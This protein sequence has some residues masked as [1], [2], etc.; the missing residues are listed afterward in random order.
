VLITS[1]QPANSSR[2]SSS[3]RRVSTS[4]SFDGSS[5]SSTLPPVHQRLRQV[6]APAL[7]AGEV[8]DDL[9]LVAALE[10][11]AADVGAA[12]HFEACRR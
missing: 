2:A 7:A 6:Q 5:S 10:V 4:R 1:T 8:A 9:L 11:E 12:G 3:A